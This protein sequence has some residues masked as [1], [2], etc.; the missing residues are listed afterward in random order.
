M[1]N[2]NCGIKKWEYALYTVWFEIFMLGNGYCLNIYVFKKDWLF[3]NLFFFLFFFSQKLHPSPAVL[4]CAL[5]FY[6]RYDVMGWMNRFKKLVLVI[7]NLESQKINNNKTSCKKTRFI[8]SEKIKKCY[9]IL[10]SVFGGRYTP[11]QRFCVAELFFFLGSE[12]VNKAFNNE[13][14]VMGFRTK[15]IAEERFLPCV[16]PIPQAIRKEFFHSFILLVDYESTP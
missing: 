13:C 2:M 6:I 11:C 9:V 12:I 7:Y 8:I 4:R 5:W 14:G 1:K 3:W 10:V 15:S 16:L